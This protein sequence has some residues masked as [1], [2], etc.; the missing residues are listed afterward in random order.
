MRLNVNKLLHT[1]GSR[2]EVRFE[3][4]LSDLEFGGAYPVTRPVVVD[5]QLYAAV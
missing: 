1:P 5:G 4:E 2:Q 3:M